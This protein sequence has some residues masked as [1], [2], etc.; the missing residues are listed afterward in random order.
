MTWK[1]HSPL[2]QEEITQPCYVINFKCLKILP[3]ELP[4]GSMLCGLFSNSEMTRSKLESFR[5]L[6]LTRA[7]CWKRH[8]PQIQREPSIHSSSTAGW[9]RHRGRRRCTEGSSKDCWADALLGQ[10]K[11]LSRWQYKYNSVISQR[12][13]RLV[14]V[15][16]PICEGNSKPYVS[17]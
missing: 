13:T 12:R 3:S 5:R 2:L 8:S 17:I 9:R 4:R 10:I 16:V 11:S 14:C 6:S 1:F 15:N 7:A